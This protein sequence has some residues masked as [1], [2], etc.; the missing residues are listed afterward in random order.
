MNTDREEFCPNIPVHGGAISGSG[1]P[2]TG[3]ALVLGSFEDCEFKLL[4][5]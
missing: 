1:G 2:E 4:G 3:P 5:T